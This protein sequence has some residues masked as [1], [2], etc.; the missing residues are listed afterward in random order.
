MDKP[1]VIYISNSRPLAGELLAAISPLNFRRSKDDCISE[2]SDALEYM[3]VVVLVPHVK[4]ILQSYAKDSRV[5]ISKGVS[6][7]FHAGT[8]TK[9]GGTVLS[10]LYI[11]EAGELSQQFLATRTIKGHA[12]RLI[13]GISPEGVDN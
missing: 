9:D 6:K 11:S 2:V 4:R 1:E 7:L 12:A 13:V 5:I 10:G 8:F 3:G